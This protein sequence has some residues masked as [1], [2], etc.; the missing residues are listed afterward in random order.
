MDIPATAASIMAAAQDLRLDFR[1]I[2]NEANQWRSQGG[3]GCERTSPKFRSSAFTK[4]TDKYQ[5]LG[6]NIIP[7]HYPP[8]Q[9]GVH[10]YGVKEPLVVNDRA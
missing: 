10:P 6:L 4:N 5:G 9:G 2:K 8:V 3:A 7:F 1:T